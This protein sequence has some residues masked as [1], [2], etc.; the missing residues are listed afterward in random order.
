MHSG[1]RG[2]DDEIGTP[3]CI[4]PVSIAAACRLAAIAA[5]PCRRTK[6]PAGRRKSQLLNAAAQSLRMADVTERFAAIGI[7]IGGSVEAFGTFLREDTARW[8]KV[9]RAAN[10]RVE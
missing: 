7:A 8:A 4:T 2:R 3:Y 1:V 10:V 9:I 5:G 6:P